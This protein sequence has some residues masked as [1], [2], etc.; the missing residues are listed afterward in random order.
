MNRIGSERTKP[1]SKDGVISMNMGRSVPAGAETKNI[2]SCV[3][4]KK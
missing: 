3:M 1:K 4:G 2:F